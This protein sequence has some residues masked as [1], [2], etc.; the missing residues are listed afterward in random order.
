[1][2]TGGIRQNTGS[3]YADGN[4]PNANWNDDKFNVGN[5]NPDESNDNIRVR[6]EVSITKG[7]ISPFCCLCI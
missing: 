2:R 1:M 3:R 6:E 5:Y 4:V 7:L